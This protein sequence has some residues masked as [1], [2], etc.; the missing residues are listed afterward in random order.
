LQLGKPSGS[1]LC[2][3]GKQHDEGD[4]ACD[5]EDKEC[6]F[7]FGCD[8]IELCDWK[9][10]SGFG[11]GLG[12]S[13]DSQWWDGGGS[14]SEHAELVRGELRYRDDV[15]QRARRLE[16]LGGFGSKCDERVERVRRFASQCRSWFLEHNVWSMFASFVE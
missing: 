4:E 15:S 14:R 1:V 16:Q 12:F 11:C 8:G 5:Y 7:C 3:V 2:A 9:R 6:R 13:N 10:E